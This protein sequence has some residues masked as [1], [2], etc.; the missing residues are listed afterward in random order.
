MWND[1]EQN[2]AHH[3]YFVQ[4]TI[5]LN[6]LTTNRWILRLLQQFSFLL[7]VF[8]VRDKKKNFFCYCFPFKRYSDHC[9]KRYNIQLTC[10]WIFGLDYLLKK[11]CHQNQFIYK[12][13]SSSTSS[14]NRLPSSQLTE[15]NLNVQVHITWNI[16]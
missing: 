13:S 4:F 5:S 2:S 3:F 15:L 9:L 11:N 12:D 1:N 6:F 16:D 8:N 7:F 10:N 14:T